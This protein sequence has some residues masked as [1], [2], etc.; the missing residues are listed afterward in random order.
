MLFV[1][2]TLADCTSRRAELEGDWP[3]DESEVCEVRRRRLRPLL[4]I[5]RG[6]EL[7]TYDGNQIAKRTLNETEP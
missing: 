7:K 2:P 1:P 6:D 3:L 5:G 4:E